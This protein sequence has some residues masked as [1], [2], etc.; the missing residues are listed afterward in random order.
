MARRCPGPR[1]FVP[2]KNP[3]NICCPKYGCICNGIEDA[4]G[5][6]RGSTEEILKRARFEFGNCTII[7]GSVV[8]DSKCY[9]YNGWFVASYK[10]SI[11][12]EKRQL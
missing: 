5:V 1:Q 4:N 6:F 9:S 3:E 12:I 7:R 8:L 11:N 10:Q 2:R